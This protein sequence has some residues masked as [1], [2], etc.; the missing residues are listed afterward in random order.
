[1]KNFV[2]P[3]IIVRNLLMMKFI[4]FTKMGGPSNDD[5]IIIAIFYRTFKI[6]E[7]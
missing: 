1:M 3:F 7:A 5:K 6:P 2:Q 4:L